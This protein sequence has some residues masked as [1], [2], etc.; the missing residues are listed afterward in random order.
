MY[1]VWAPRGRVLCMLADGENPFSDAPSSNQSDD[2]GDS[3]NIQASDD[4]ILEVVEN[5][6]KNRF[7][8]VL[9][10]KSV[11]PFQSMEY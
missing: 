7:H 2:F 8:V 4:D 5:Y 1:I 3:M 9:S 10:A 11:L 6:Q